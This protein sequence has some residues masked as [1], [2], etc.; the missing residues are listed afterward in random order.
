MRMT[1]IFV[2]SRA[3]VVW[4]KIQPKGES[5]V[6]LQWGN[7]DGP[8]ACIYPVGRATL[9]KIAGNIRSILDRLADWAKLKDKNDLSDILHSLAVEGKKLRF[10]IFDCPAKAREVAELEG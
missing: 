1:I 10:V 6:T 4:L 5:I 9:L 8:D 3:A 2:Q 7:A